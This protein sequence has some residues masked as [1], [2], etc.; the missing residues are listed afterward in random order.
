MTHTE[1]L[2]LEYSTWSCTTWY[3]NKRMSFLEQRLKAADYRTRMSGFQGGMLLPDYITIEDE[4]WQQCYVIRNT[5]E[6]SPPACEGD[7][8]G[9]KITF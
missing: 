1:T 4:L 7:R 8:L 9:F 5:L 2:P 6:E 3:I